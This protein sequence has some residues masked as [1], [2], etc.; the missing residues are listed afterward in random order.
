MFVLCI[1]LRVLSQFG[2]TCVERCII[3]GIKGIFVKVLSLDGLDDKFYKVWLPF[4][5][6]VVFDCN[7]QVSSF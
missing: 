7:H 4:Q 3:R 2:L 6:H 5:N 1:R